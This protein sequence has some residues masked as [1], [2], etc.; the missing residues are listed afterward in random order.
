MARRTYP[1]LAAYLDDTGMT[2]AELATK[3]GFSQA[4][5]SKLVRRLQQ[6]TLDEALRISREVGVPVESLVAEAN[7]ATAFPS[8]K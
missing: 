6:P 5:I 4:Y 8:E 1:S 2:Q 7:Q 3:L